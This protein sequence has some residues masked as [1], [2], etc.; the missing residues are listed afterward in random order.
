M[1]FSVEEL[2]ERLGGMDFQGMEGRTGPSDRG[3]RRRTRAIALIAALMLVLAACNGG[4]E[5]E[6]GGDDGGPVEVTLWL[7]GESAPEDEFA[8]LEEEH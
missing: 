5:E 3:A 6:G 2:Q 7:N 8:A 4:D 1:N